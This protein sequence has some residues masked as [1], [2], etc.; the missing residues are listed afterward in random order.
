MKAERN[1]EERHG[2]NEPKK[3]Q[4][5]GQL[6]KEGAEGKKKEEEARNLTRGEE[7]H[8]KSGKPNRSPEAKRA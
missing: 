3:G 7:D 5:V 2:K 4:V 6:E 1:Q 8:G